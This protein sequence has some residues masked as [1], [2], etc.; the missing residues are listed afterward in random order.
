MQETVLRLQADLERIR[1]MPVFLAVN[2]IRKVMGY[3]S[4]LSEKSGQNE[5]NNMLETADLIQNSAGGCRTLSQWKER[6]DERKREETAGR[7][8]ISGNAGQEA[9]EDSVTFMTMHSSKGLEYDKVFILNCN[10]EVTP[11]KKARSEA[12]IEE[13]RRMFYVGMTRA[14]KELVLFYLTDPGRT[15]KESSTTGKKMLPSRFLRELQET[16]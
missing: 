15:A 5:E 14:K 8:V 12:E 11:Y 3:D 9:L 4:Y 2:Y 7:K 16:L 13:E 1:T 6:M 10:E